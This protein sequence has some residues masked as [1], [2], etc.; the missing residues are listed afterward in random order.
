MSVR[1][2][3]LKFNGVSI[4]FLL[5]N[6][7]WMIPA[8]LLGLALGYAKEGQKLAD[9]LTGG[10]AKKWT[11]EDFKVFTGQ[12]LK[13][14]REGTPEL[15][16][17]SATSQL[18]MLT[19]AGVVKVLQRSRA[20]LA[21][22][23]RDFLAENAT[24]LFKDHLTAL[25][26]PKQMEL[27][28]PDKDSGS[29]LSDLM[30]IM[31]VGAKKGLMTKKEQRLILNKML[32]I[33]MV[34]FTRA[35]KVTHVLNPDGTVD[36]TSL[37][38]M[39]QSALAVREGQYQLLSSGQYHPAYMDWQT[40]ED[41][42]KPFGLKADLVKKY[43]KARCLGKGSDLPNNLGR[44]YVRKHN[45]GFPA[46][47]AHGYIVFDETAK[48]LGGIAIYSKLSDN[49]LVWRNFWSP[50]A[51]REINGLVS[52]DRKLPKTEE[53]AEAET[54]GPTPPALAVIEIETSQAIAKQEEHQN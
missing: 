36:P 12:E 43:I 30:R 45:G 17:P 22:K 8:K 9:A 14:L 28:I 27:D 13:K 47:D 44:D 37:P 7:V 18:L 29:E 10:W 24:S 46:P 53:E 11:A 51:V 6:S 1:T 41:I 32:D 38:A 20:G 34:A 52:I 25:K 2:K 35:N 39:T 23:F 3:S 33:K 49:Q 50:E 16:V 26:P 5:I 54:S 31:E 15:G 40:A 42:G 21:T 19:P 48:S 4:T